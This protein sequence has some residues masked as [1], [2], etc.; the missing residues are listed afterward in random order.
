M[1]FDWDESMVSRLSMCCSRFMFLA[2]L[3]VSF[4]SWAED[5]KFSIVDQHGTALSKAVVEPIEIGS[6][7]LDKHE[8]LRIVDQIDK[9]F[10][11]QQLVI[12]AGDSVEF[13]NSDNIRHHVYSFSKARVFE[14]KLYAD[15][16]KRPVVF[17]EPG[18]VV[19]GCNIHDTMIGYIYIAK[20]NHTQETDDNGRA[21]LQLDHPIKTVSVWHAQQ[22]SGA[23]SQQLIDLAAL[24][25][26]KQGE[27]VIE[28]QITEPAPRNSF[29]DVFG[30]DLS[31]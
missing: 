1:R 11:P 19:L 10:S 9:Q 31:N 14:L 3:L 21:E 29:K 5:Y 23:E 13:P 30:A 15:K 28:L 8:T 7:S 2:A 17:I 6:L 18:V 16:P 25:K 24:Q 12:L 27:F 4:P 26:N 22:A 20:S